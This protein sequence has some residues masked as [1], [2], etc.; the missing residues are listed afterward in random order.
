MGLALVTLA[1]CAHEYNPQRFRGEATALTHVV[2]LTAPDGTDAF[3]RAGHARVSP[4]GRWVVFRGVPRGQPADAYGLFV[5][6]LRWAAEPVAVPDHQ[7]LT[8]LP[9]GTAPDVAT[10]VGVRHI[11]GLD[12]PVRITRVGRHAGGACFSPDGFSLAFAAQD[13]TGA[14]RLYRADNWEQAVAMADTARGVDLAQHPVSP[15]SLSVGDCDWS[16]DG[17][18]I[19]V[20]AADGLYALPFDGSQR[21]FRL[22]PTAAAGPAVSPDGKRLAYRAGPAAASRVVVADVVRDVAGDVVGV[23]DEHPLTHDA[24]ATGPCWLPDGRRLLYATTRHGDG[25][26]ELY[27]MASTDG[28]AKTRL[29]QSPGPDLLPAVTADGSHLVWTATRGRDAAPQLFAADLAVPP[30]G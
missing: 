12:R 5:A 29:T 14:S 2:Q 28:T 17:K 18:S 4:D 30:G 8:P 27:V 19:V 3:A 26:V 16:P 13:A 23:K 25:N 15:E 10:A 7:Y 21:L 22:G 9:Q 1:G 24:A 6:H 20:A 11:A